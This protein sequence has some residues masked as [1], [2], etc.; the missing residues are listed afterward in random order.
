[1]Q[2]EKVHFTKEKET[3]LFTLYGKALQS[4]SADPVLP[5]KWAEDAV[6]RI[7]YDFGGLKVREYES[8]LIAIRSSQF[9]LLTTN[10]LAQNPDATVLHLGCGMDSRVFRVDPPAGVHWFDVDYP[11]VIELRRRLYPERPGYRVIGSALEDPN[12]LAQVPAD[13]SAMIVAEGVMMYL[14]EDI[15]RSLLNRLT[16]HFPGGQMAFD[17][18]NQLALRGAQRRGIK[19]TGAT[20]GWAIDDPQD[21]Q[22]LAPRLELITEQ[23]PRDLN[24][25]SKMPWWSRTLV[26]LMDPIPALR[27]MNRVLLYRF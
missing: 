3:L 7:D 25:F 10:Y 13:R 22:K 11:K 9:D 5:D 15:V 27:R 17:A 16:A 18:W 26:R 12:W 20:F 14:T 4:R 21:I 2:S 8:R 24:A 23:R 1:M 6:R 19:G